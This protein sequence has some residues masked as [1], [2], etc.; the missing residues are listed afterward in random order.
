MNKISI[1]LFILITFGITRNV[2]FGQNLPTDTISLQSPDYTFRSIGKGIEL[3]ETD[4]PLKS[5]VNDSKLTILRIEPSL[6]E[7]ELKAYTEIGQKR[8][9]KEWADTFDFD[10]V[11]NAGMYELSDGKTS[12]GFLKNFNHYNNPTFREN[13]N[14]MIAFNPIDT[15]ETPFKVLDLE[16]EN[17]HEIK[18]DYQ[19]FAQGL[20]MIDCNHGLIGW[21]KRKQSCS[22]LVTAM[23]PLH[24]VYFI[25]TRSPYT[26]NEMIQFMSSM[27]FELYNAIYMEGG[28]ETSLY[29]KTDELTI[30]KMGSYVSETYEK[31]TNESFWKLPNVIGIRLKQ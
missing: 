19:T 5:V 2:V 7:F 28:P 31:D 26:H 13:Y 18:D 25:F 29:V 4:A 23:D 1:Y 6:F 3:C 10:I 21:N 24:R 16:C 27:P 9:V 12:R 22:M 11:L 17:W 20:R 14:S 15:L 30:E 8:T